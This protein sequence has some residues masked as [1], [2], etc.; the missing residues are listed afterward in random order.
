[1]E[2]GW[3]GVQIWLKMLTS[4]PSTLIT[5]PYVERCE[6]VWLGGLPRPLTKCPKKFLS[7]PSI[8]PKPQLKIYNAKYDYV[9]IMFSSEIPYNRNFRG[10]KFTK[11][12]LW[13]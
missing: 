11:L 5:F 3:Y 6:G 8:F 7:T 4:A 9:K 2:V 10:E 1:M 12:I 13:F